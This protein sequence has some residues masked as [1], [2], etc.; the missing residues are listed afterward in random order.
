[1]IESKLDYTFEGTAIKFDETPFY[2]KFKSYHPSGKGVDFISMDSTAYI[3][4][5]VKNCLGYEQENMWRTKTDFINESG[6]ESFDIEIAKKVEGTLACLLGAKVAYPLAEADELKP[7]SEELCSGRYE[8]GRKSLEVILFLE[9]DFGS[10]TRKKS[11][12]MKR[13]QDK[14]GQKLKWLNCNV[15]VVDSETYRTNH[16]TVEHVTT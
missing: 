6:E 8:N 10:K 12:I 14:L 3:L 4:V 13:I 2:T 11:M 7:Y 16:F 15:R 9:G 5:E 1:V